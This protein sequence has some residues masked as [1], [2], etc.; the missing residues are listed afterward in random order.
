MRLAIV[1]LLVGA[2]LVACGGSKPAEPRESTKQPASKK[3]LEIVAELAQGPGNIA[4]VGSRIFISQ[5]QFY[6]PKH[7]VVEVVG[8]DTKPFAEGAV[9]SVLG[10]RSDGK[11]LWL[12]DNGMRNKTQR[13]LV[14]WDPAADKVERTIDLTSVTPEDSFLNDL[15]VDRKND[16]VYIADPAGGKN[17]ALI[18]VDLK[19]NTARRVLQGHEAVVPTDVDLII[20]GTPLQIKQPD[21]KLIRPRVGV[22]PI[23]LSENGEW[24]FFGPMHAK[25]LYK[26]DTNDLRDPDTVPRVY[27]FADRPITDG[28]ILRGST[29]YLGDLGS[30]AIGMIDPDDKYREVVRDPL[31]AWVDAFAPAPNDDG[32]YVV[33]NQLHRSAVLNAGVDATKPPFHIVHF[34]P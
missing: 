14:A 9:D 16:V 19:T 5:H 2:A 28:I 11:L 6:N 3:T 27:A 8:S 29:I 18:V 1:G 15:A 34:R 21:G 32:Y 31:L 24:L 26:V 23:A 30:N 4:V 22:N 12:L 25:Q 17:A 10:I 20:D 7:T 33:V 13:K